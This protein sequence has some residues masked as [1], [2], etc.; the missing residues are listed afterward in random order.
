M[1]ELGPF[2]VNKDG[3]TLSRNNY[4]WNSDKCKYIVLES[5]AGV[6]FSYS[7]TSLDYNKSGD[8]RTAEDS[9]TFLVNWLE[10]FLNTSQRTSTSPE[11][12]TPFGGFDPCT[13]DYI[14]NYLNIPEVQKAFHANSTGLPG[15]WSACNG[16]SDGRIPVTLTRYS[17]SRLSL[18]LVG[19]VGYDGLALV[20]VRG[21]GHFVPSYQPAR[22]LTLFTS[23]LEGKLPPSS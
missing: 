1:E 5:T 18:L 7:N 10:R 13:E 12:A 8:Q 23:F 4:A 9:Y 2:R 22:A 11:R 17:V 19:G 3:S 16:D 21:A 6:G 14:A 15:P 20:T